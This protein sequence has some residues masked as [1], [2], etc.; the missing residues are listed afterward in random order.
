[1][2]WYQNWRS[3]PKDCWY[4]TMFVS[5]CLASLPM[6]VWG[7]F[8]KTTSLL[9]SFTLRAVTTHAAYSKASWWPCMTTW[10]SQQRYMMS[11]LYVDPGHFFSSPCIN[12]CGCVFHL[13]IRCN[14][15]FACFLVA[16]GVLF[17]VIFHLFFWQR[18]L[19]SVFSLLCPFA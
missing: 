1:M 15:S 8:K 12:A 14:S 7:S 6:V 9:L 10:S 13:R 3:K 5:S 11:F 16:V 4:C 2:I 19:R 17:P 18:D